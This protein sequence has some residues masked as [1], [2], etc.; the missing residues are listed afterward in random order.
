MLN[1]GYLASLV[2]K[3][4]INLYARRFTSQWVVIF[5]F[6][7]KAVVPSVL[8]CPMLISQRVWYVTNPLKMSDI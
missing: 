2:V 1:Q 7:S 4:R 3:V 6:F 8:S 5:F